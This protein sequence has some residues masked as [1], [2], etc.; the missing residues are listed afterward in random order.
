MNWG[1]KTAIWILICVPLISTPTSADEREETKV[2][3]LHLTIPGVRLVNPGGLAG[4]LPGLGEFCSKPYWEMKE[5][6]RPGAPFDFGIFAM[7]NP[8]QAIRFSS[9]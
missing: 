5:F 7:T 4:A 3:P 6:P 8:C 1:L 2:D 9:A